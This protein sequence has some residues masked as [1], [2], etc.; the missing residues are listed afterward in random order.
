MLTLTKLNSLHILVDL[1]KCFI[2]HMNS[3]NIFSVYLFILDFLA[4]ESS[5]RKLK[6]YSVIYAI[7]FWKSGNSHLSIN[8]ILWFT[9]LFE[10]ANSKYIGCG[11][12]ESK[13]K[14]YNVVY[15]N[16]THTFLYPPTSHFLHKMNSNFV[17]SLEFFQMFFMQMWV[18]IN[19]FII[20]ILKIKYGIIDTFIYFLLH[21][22]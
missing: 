6:V 2:M 19:S 20:F 16:K 11:T 4:K 17:S 21:C 3:W 22:K 5:W 12:Y 10:K 9:F 13:L 7:C 8:H 1:Y 15:S 14:T 18:D